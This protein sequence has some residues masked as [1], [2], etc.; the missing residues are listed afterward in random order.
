MALIQDVQAN[1]TQPKNLSINDIVQGLRINNQ[2]Y[3]QIYCMAEDQLQFNRMSG[4]R[5]STIS[6][7]QKMADI[8]KR[9]AKAYPSLSDDTLGGRNRY[10][11]ALIRKCNYNIRRRQKGIRVPPAPEVKPSRTKRKE[12][13]RVFDQGIQDS[14]VRTVNSDS[15]INSD[16][17]NDSDQATTLN[18]TRASGTL[19]AG[20]IVTTKKPGRKPAVCRLRDLVEDEKCGENIRLDDLQF[21]KWICM[22]QEDV[23]YNPKQ[24]TIYY[25]C[26]GESLLDV[27]N[28]RC[29]KAA[30]EEM[31]IK[32]LSRFS[33]TIGSDQ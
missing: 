5:L 22:L 32:G 29:W 15:T 33:F 21:D 19:G 13:T 27:W 3:S 7:K 25:S 30:L 24:E 9:I 17:T 6:N 11:S 16:S 31:S 20:I 14:K 2:I 12:E 28:E 23:G 10:L 1:P 18:S 4:T 8:C 26:V